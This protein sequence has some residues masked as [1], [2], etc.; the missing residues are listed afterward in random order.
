M[1]RQSN[2]FSP[3]AG[4]QPPELAGRDEILSDAKVAI[5]RALSAR[6]ARSALLLGLRGVGKTV[7]LNRIA[8]IAE[9]VGCVTVVLEAPESRP[10]AELLVPPLRSLLFKLSK[11]EKAKVL[12]KQAL[13]ALRAFASAFKVTAGDIEFGV[14]PDH[15]VADS[16]NLEADLPELLLTVAKAARA[17]DKAVVLIVDEVQYLASTDLSALIVTIH[18]VGQKSLPLLMFGAGLPQLAGLAGEAKSY[19]ERLFSYPTVGPLDAEAAR[20]AL[21]T[22]IER[23]G[24]LIDDDALSVLVLQTQGYP[25]FLQEWGA[26]AWNV[27][28]SS[29]I[30]IED[31]YIAGEQALRRLDEGFFR[32]RL[33]RLTPRE[34]DYVRAMAQLGP[35]PHRSGDIAKEMGMKVTTAGPL[36]SALITKGMIYSPSHGDTAFTVPMFDEFMR[37]AM[38]EWEPPSAPSRGGRSRSSEG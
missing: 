27:A 11:S 30:K 6:S 32:V 15:G 28:V 13:G 33:D 5:G 16:G 29:T 14:E 23:E 36:R 8:E 7:L 22:P 31:A 21:R 25:Y 4:T 35:G 26:Q 3:G 12:A 38:P 17:A 2:P 37:R 10:I 34:K 1:D 18:K 9:E 24:A 19:A 20:A